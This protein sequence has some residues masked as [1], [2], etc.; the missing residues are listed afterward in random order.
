[1]ANESRR[2]LSLTPESLIAAT[3]VIPAGEPFF[4]LNLL[5]YREH[6]HYPDGRSPLSGRAAYHE[7][8]VGTFVTIA[9]ELHVAVE[10]AFLGTVLTGL[11]APAGEQWHEL[12]LV[13][14]PSFAVFRRIVES[15][16]YLKDAAPHR[17][18]SLEDWRLLATQKLPA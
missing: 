1:M 17:L 2:S 18:A 16:R 10:L 6:A 12:A 4:M 11:V 14:Y 7:G 13:R 9:K 3:A 5:R 15:E 8:Y